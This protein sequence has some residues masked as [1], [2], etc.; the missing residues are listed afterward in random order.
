MRLLRLLRTVRLFKAVVIVDR[1][2]DYLGVRTALVKI[3]QFVLG[4]MIVIHIIACVFYLVP[5]MSKLDHESESYEDSTWA[6][7]YANDTISE[8]H[9][10]PVDG[11]PHLGSEIKGPMTDSWVCDLGISRHSDTENSLRYLTA[12]YFSITT[13]STIG[14]GDISPNLLN[15]TELLFT[16][17]AEFVGMFLFSYVVSVSLPPSPQSLS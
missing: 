9:S 3:I 15:E 1:L 6:Q 13:I 7:L 5:T 14:Y 2:R 11:L 8:C 4:L 12:C 16:I 17:V 10:G